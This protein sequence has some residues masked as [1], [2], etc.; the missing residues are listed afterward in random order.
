MEDLSLSRVKDQLSPIESYKSIPSYDISESSLSLMLIEWCLFD[1]FVGHPFQS[2]RGLGLSPISGGLGE[3]LTVSPSS[4]G[5]LTSDI[6]SKT[7]TRDGFGSSSD[8]SHLL[9]TLAGVVLERSVLLW[10]HQNIW[11]LTQNLHKIA[12]KWLQNIT[13]LHSSLAYLTFWSLRRGK[14]LKISK[15]LTFTL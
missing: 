2:G 5:S 10:A 9:Q 14:E 4:S 7:E 15:R 1:N 11:I 12:L 3:K 13:I 6:L 8:V